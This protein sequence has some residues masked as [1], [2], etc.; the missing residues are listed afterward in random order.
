MATRSMLACVLALVLATPVAA[1]AAESW[2]ERP[3]RLIV[4]FAPGGSSDVSARVFSQKL[5]ERLG[6]QVVVDNRSSAGGIVGADLLARAPADGYTLGLGNVSS[7]TASPLIFSNV[8]YHPVKSFTYIGFIGTVPVV[9]MVHPSFPAR[10]IADLVRM[11]KAQ[12]G[13]IDYGTAGN[14]TIGHIVGEMFKLKAGVN[15]THVPYRGSAFM[16]TDLRTNGIPFGI[17]AL[18]QN[19]E[20][21]KAGVVRPLA[22]SGARRV[23]MA[24]G[25]PTLVELG[26]PDLIAENWLGF[27]G[28]AGVPRP[29]V[30]RVHREVMLLAKQPEIG[31]RLARLGITHQ[32]LTPAEFRDYVAR[33]YASWGPVVKAAQ[34]KVN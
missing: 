28:P 2:P 7:Q 19:A 33:L 29:I 22:I 10:S 34:I 24:P 14:G 13:K 5:S 3:I 11:A 21:I 17:D 18:P 27:L 8:A 26:Y 6:Q 32:P 31:E 25:I 9:L 4:P 20:H 23:A 15:L 30:E 12:P 16:F 1:A